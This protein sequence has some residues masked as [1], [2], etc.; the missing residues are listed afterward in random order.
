MLHDAAVRAIGVGLIGCGTVGTGVAR[1]LRDHAAQIRARLGGDI[2][3]RRILARDP[4]KPRA[5]EIDRALLT[6]DAEQFFAEPGIDVVVEVVGGEE[7]A[8]SLV[9]RALEAGRPVVTA[10]KLLIATR[11]HELAELAESRGAD[12][13]FEAAVAGSIPVIRT[14]REALAAER[15]T[16]VVGIV[17]GTSNFVLTRMSED[18]M[19]FPDAVR[20]AQ[21]LGFAEADPSLD[22][23]GHDAAQK[24]AILAML[25]FS[26]RVD[27]SRVHVEG[28]ESLSP[29]DVALARRFGYVVKSLAIAR[30]HGEAIELRVHPTLVPHDHVIAGVRDQYNCV[31][32]EG[33]AVGSLLLSG[34]GA[35]ALPT[36]VSVVSDVIDV[37]RNL[38]GGAAGRV[39][40]RA[41]PGAS[42]RVR[43]ILDMDD[44]RSRYYL[45]VTCGDHA[46]TLARIT[47]A[48][49]SHD[50]PVAE[51]VQEPAGGAGAVHVALTT[52]V[53]REANVRAAV[54][55]IDALRVVAEPSRVLRID[56]W[57]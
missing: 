38:L 21:E 34:H 28:I 9:R 22:V 2:A 52:R 29:I 39:P 42:L 55:E 44:V 18:R 54:G 8:G 43:P 51:L 46:R 24:L 57:E 12:L 35:G 16:A 17:N 15:V 31:Y 53:V 48:L 25:A 41:S 6:F 50:V 14:L 7:P 47:D 49:G 5:P 33:P 13:Y 11:G 56:L 45:R 4:G 26:A 36:A 19:P 30:D 27:L 3:I 20:R 40:S 1:L 32:V 23:G 10:N 37:A